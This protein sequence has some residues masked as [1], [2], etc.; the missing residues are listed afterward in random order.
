MSIKQEDMDLM[1]RYSS[2]LPNMMW[3]I[4]DGLLDE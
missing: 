1:V 3:E 4:G 2:G